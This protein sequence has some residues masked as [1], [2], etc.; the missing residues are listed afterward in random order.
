M[1]TPN[2]AK[3]GDTSEPVDFWCAFKRVHEVL[4]TRVIADAAEA[5]GLSEPDLTILAS[6]SRAGGALRQSELAAALGW[7]RTRISHQLTRMAKRALVTR[8]RTGG[9]AV[10]VT[11]TA[12]GRAAVT[13]VRPLLD[14]AVRRHFTDRLSAREIETLRSVF[15]RM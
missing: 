13:A 6:L 5:A 1:S 9:A 11:L 15:D 7:D 4:R 8:E 2:G 14:A 3:L 10:T 12:D